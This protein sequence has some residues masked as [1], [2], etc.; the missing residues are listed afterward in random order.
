MK[1]N[2]VPAQGS[3]VGPFILR[4]RRMTMSRR[5]SLPFLVL[6]L[7]AAGCGAGE[8]AGAG[9]PNPAQDSFPVTIAAANGPVTVE[10]RPEAVVSLSPTATEMLY[11][12]G[13]GDQM[14]AVD[15]QSTYPP[16][17]P[18]TDLSGITP[19]V[20]AITSYEP[21]LV[22]ITFDPGDLVSS[23]SALGIP[24][25]V[26][27]GATSL[28]EAYR[29]M[30]QLGA[31]TGN[32]AG[33][34]ELVAAMQAD[35]AEVVAAAPALEPAPTYYHELDP[36]FYTATSATFIGEVYGLLGLE[37]IADPADA[38][39]F[40][41]PQLS[42]EFILEQDPD[43]IFLADTTCCDQTA[44][45]VAERPGWASLTAVAAGRVVELDDDVASRWGP[46]VVDFLR[47][48]AEAVT[49]LEATG[50]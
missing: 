20:E 44:A 6:L 18:R 16:E 37:N 4:S 45:S 40:G 34:A 30:E 27:P 32:V 25:L 33:A 43:L 38:D 5:I 3:P 13:V 29:Q 15:D 49:A 12:I 24:V 2:P 9:P 50:S 28:D 22:V 26:M 31:A 35:I 8:E 7:A 41:Y 23:L 36:S 19:N 48:V 21:D 14:V 17:A 47:A 1:V 42:A 46:R 39:G 11:A 10:R